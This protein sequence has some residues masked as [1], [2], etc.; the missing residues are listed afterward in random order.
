MY[1]HILLVVPQNIRKGT[2]FKMHI[3]LDEQRFSYI[4]TS[5][6]KKQSCV[7]NQY[8]RRLHWD[9]LWFEIK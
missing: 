7:V 1:R 3:R 2:Y 6:I 4:D 9:E 8:S 5:S